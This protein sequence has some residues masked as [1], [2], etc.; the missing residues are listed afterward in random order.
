MNSWACPTKFTLVVAAQPQGQASVGVAGSDSC[1]SCRLSTAGFAAP[2]PPVAFTSRSARVAP[3]RCFTDSQPAQDGPYATGAPRRCTSRA[4]RR[5]LP[6]S[7]GAAPDLQRWQRRFDERQMHA[8]HDTLRVQLDGRTCQLPCGAC[9]RACIAHSTL[10]THGSCPCMV[11]PWV[12]A[13]RRQ[14]GLG[15]IAYKRK[16]PPKA[17]T[18]AVPARGHDLDEALGEPSLSSNTRCEEHSQQRRREFRVLSLEY[19]C[20]RWRLLGED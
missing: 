5:A 3:E 20:S 2:T 17:R 13:L 6:P 10:G 11:R 9:P 1:L 7:K 14:E 4:E 12:A 15:C 18:T 8:R 19:V 16:V